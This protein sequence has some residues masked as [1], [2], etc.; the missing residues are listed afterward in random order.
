MIRI[1]TI[2]I[3][4][5][6]YKIIIN[7]GDYSQYVEIYGKTKNVPNHQPDHHE[8]R[9][10]N[11]TNLT[12]TECSQTNTYQGTSKLPPGSL[13]F[14]FLRRSCWKPETGRVITRARFKRGGNH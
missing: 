4:M 10:K 8:A 13:E 7:W 12:E 3:I 2:T 9:I 5:I 11:S 1:T 6:I 14:L